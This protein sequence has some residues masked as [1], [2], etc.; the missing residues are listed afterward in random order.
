MLFTH[1]IN[2]FLYPQAFIFYGFMVKYFLQQKKD[3]PFGLSVSYAPS[4]A[5]TPDTL[6]KSQVL[7]Q[8]S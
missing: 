5:R 7:Y 3:N 4:G 1:Y 6:I 2:I 8:L